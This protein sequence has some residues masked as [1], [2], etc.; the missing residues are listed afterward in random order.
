[1]FLR[2]RIGSILFFKFGVTSNQQRQ[3]DELID[4]ENDQEES[5]DGESGDGEI[6]RIS[7]EKSAE[8]VF[9]A[10]DNFGG[11]QGFP[12]VAEADDRTGNKPRHAHRPKEIGNVIPT[13]EAGNF[14]CL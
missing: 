9:Q 4:A 12:S 11:N 10:D 3:P 13:V 7:L 6:L 1:M 14:Y 8:A 5:N 2:L